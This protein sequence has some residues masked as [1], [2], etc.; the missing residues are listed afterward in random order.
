MSESTLTRQP[1][2]ESSKMDV[3]FILL[4]S[5]LPLLLIIV[6]NGYF[7]Q[8][9]EVSTFWWVL[10][11]MNIDVAH[12]YSTLFRFYWDKDTYQKYKSLLIIIPVASF[13]VGAF[14]HFMGAMI[15]WRVIAYLAVF[16]FIRQQ[17]GFMRLYSR[18]ESFDRKLRFIDSV[19]IYM[20]TLYPLIYWHLNLT[21]DL[22]WFVK[23]DFFS[24]SNSEWI[25]TISILI[26]ILSIVVYVG[27]EALVFFRTGQVNIPKNLLVAGTY[28]SWYLGIVVYRGDLIFTLF[29]VVAHGV[30]YMALVYFFSRKKL[31]QPS[32]IP[33]K[34]IAIFVITVIVLAYLE[35]GLWDG[36]VW[37]D[38]EGVF[39]LFN[40]L[41]FVD[42]PIVLSIIVPLLALPQITHYVVDGFIW[43]IQ[44]H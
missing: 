12:V 28:L 22:Y 30:P 8:H 4:P 34:G 13:I 6:F 7:S 37:R 31:R 35:E 43:K 19:A 24:I 32:V 21:A 39:P 25:S 10:L 41:P 5:V 16:H 29:N 42:D 38:H 33:W 9:A 36:L 23:G 26:Y 17:Y 15:F 20:A 27:K 11:V 1:W 44:K 18:K 2:L 14:L 3:L 40:G